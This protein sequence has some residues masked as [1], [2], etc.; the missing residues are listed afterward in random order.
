LANR[1]TNVTTAQ[2]AIE[3]IAGATHRYR[4]L[5]TGTFG[6]A[7]TAS[8]FLFGR[9]AA[10]GVTPTTPILL[11]PEETSD[12]A[13]E[14]KTALAWGTSPTPPTAAMRRINLPATIG[15]GIILTFPRG[16]SVALNGTLIYSNSGAT[17]VQDLYFVADE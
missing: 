6:A 7:A 2:A 16:I 12:A 8:V 13:P 1:T 14:C 17:G 3:L 5:E 10:I 9:P 15:A 11:L 4:L